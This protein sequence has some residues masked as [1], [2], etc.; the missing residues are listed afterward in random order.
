MSAETCY[1]IHMTGLTVDHLK[2]YR[3]MRTYGFRRSDANFIM[4]GFTL[5]TGHSR[6]SRDNE[7][8][9]EGPQ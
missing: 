5:A 8:T 3:A 2:M 9:K 6:L 4:F 1:R 7:F